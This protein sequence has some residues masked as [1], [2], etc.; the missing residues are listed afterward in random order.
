MKITK[1]Y[2]GVGLAVVALVLYLVYSK[3]KTAAAAAGLAEGNKYADEE[4]KKAVGADQ[5]FE[6]DDSKKNMSAQ[7]RADYEAQEAEWEELQALRATYK[8]L[9]GKS[10]TG[11]TK[12]QLE[13]LIANEKELDAKI[14]ELAE[15]T[16]GTY[17]KSDERYDT[18]SEIDQLIIQAQADKDQKVLDDKKAAWDARKVSIADDV[19]SLRNNILNDGSHATAHKWPWDSAL[20]S[21]FDNMTEKELWYANE[22]FK[23]TGGVRTSANY[24]AAKSAFSVRYSLPAA[25]PEGNRTTKRPNAWMIPVVKESMSK[26]LQNMSGKTVNAYGEV[27]SI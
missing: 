21:R 13:K 12:A 5:G 23:S 7:D 1:V 27:V 6:Y 22:Y 25:F 8:T 26:K 20:L 2:I 18:V 10:A 17:D 15:L 9:T 11:Y 24:G 14:K 19:E 3:T 16:G 4:A